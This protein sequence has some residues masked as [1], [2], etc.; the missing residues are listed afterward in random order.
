MHLVGSQAA[1]SLVLLRIIDYKGVIEA[2]GR[3]LFLLSFFS[4]GQATRH[5]QIGHFSQP[6]W[7]PSP[8]AGP[9]ERAGWVHKER[10]GAPQ[11]WI[12]SSWCHDRN[13]LAMHTKADVRR[14]REC[15]D[16]F[17]CTEAVTFIPR[18]LSETAP[19]LSSTETRLQRHQLLFVG[20]HCMLQDL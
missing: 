6:A 4:N 5:R 17:S 20:R 12:D 7:L 2:A 14:A 15:R 9:E 1:T 11:K 16:S 19:L 3:L 13:K 18:G 8:L 10:T